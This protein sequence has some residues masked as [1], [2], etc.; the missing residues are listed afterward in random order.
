MPVV[1]G[2]PA[3]PPR[4]LRLG[5]LCDVPSLRSL[6]PPNLSVTN[7]WLPDRQQYGPVRARLNGGE[8]RGLLGLRRALPQRELPPA[9]IVPRAELV[10]DLAI[11]ADRL[12]S[13]CLVQPDA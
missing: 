1:G 12:E 9:D 10:A 2:P 4:S 7:H 8:R 5:E 13:G 6:L 11:D 3:S